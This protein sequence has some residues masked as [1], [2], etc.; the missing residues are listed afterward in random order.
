MPHSSLL[1]HVYAPGPVGEPRYASVSVAGA[2]TTASLVAAAGA[3][4]VIKVLSVTI[5]P[6]A[7]STVVIK[8]ATTALTPTL[9]FAAAGVTQVMDRTGV[10]QTAA[11]EALTCDTGAGAVGF[12]IKYIVMG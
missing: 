4:K 10:V 1:N 9:T 5:S 3:G 8:S 7:A 2:Q 12:L 6:A 11:N